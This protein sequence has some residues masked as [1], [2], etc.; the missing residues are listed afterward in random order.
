MTTSESNY[1]IDNN[2]QQCKYNPLGMLDEPEYQLAVNIETYFFPFLLVLGTLGNVFS[3]LPLRHL[4]LHAWSTCYYLF[5]LCAVDLVILYI[6]C[7]GTWYAKITDYYVSIK[8]MNSSNATCK[9]FLFITNVLLQLWPW[10]MVALCVEL[11]F[12]TR[13]PLRTYQMCTWER[14]RAT[15]LLITLLLVCLNLNYFWTWGI[16]DGTG[17]VYIEEFSTNFREYIWP[18]IDMFVKHILPLAAASGCFAFTIA[19]LLHSSHRQTSYD[20]VLKNYFMDVLALKQ[21][22]H[23]LLVLSFLFI[24]VKTF[25]ATLSIL[26]FF[27]FNGIQVPCEEMSKMDA[28][29]TLIDVTM[30]AA[31][32]C[33]LSLKFCVY[34]ATCSSFRQLC[35]SRMWKFSCSSKKKYKIANKPISVSNEGKSANESK[36]LLHSNGAGEAPMSLVAEKH[37]NLAQPLWQSTISTV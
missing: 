21:I 6:H 8:V 34:F 5:I 24:L 17:C 20:S 23:A 10:L 27:R 25:M 36:T 11:M 13:F 18:S 15:V 29:F 3:L 22:K 28:R 32:Y 26:D 9:I 4:S 16:V 30:D 1:T 33:F 31:C 19:H 35:Y 12:S 14:A 37:S 2:S 7:G